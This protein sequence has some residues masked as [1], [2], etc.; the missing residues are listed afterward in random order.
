MGGGGRDGGGNQPWWH[1]TTAF[2]PNVP[3]FAPPRG[4]LVELMGS[5]RPI[6]CGAGLLRRGCPLTVLPPGSRSEGW[7]KRADMAPWWLASRAYGPRPPPTPFATYVVVRRT[8]GRIGRGSR[9]RV[10]S[11]CPPPRGVLARPQQGTSRGPGKAPT[12]ERTPSYAYPGAW[13][14]RGI[15]CHACTRVPN[16]CNMIP[17]IMGT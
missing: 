16:Y 2:A 9:H 1:Q 15:A 5:D 8:G 6:Y 13:V 4:G 12:G 3:H 14:P 10:A 11:S 7:P 17:S